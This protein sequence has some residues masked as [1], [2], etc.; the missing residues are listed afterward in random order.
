MV[1]DISDKESFKNIKG[2]MDCNI[3][4]ISHKSLEIDKYA[5]EKVRLFLV[6][7]KLDMD[8]KRTVTFEEGYELANSEGF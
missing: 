2:W 8:S 4:K 1:Y 6:G 5:S 7:N 3:N